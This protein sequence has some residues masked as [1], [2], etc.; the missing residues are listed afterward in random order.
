MQHDEEEH[1]VLHEIGH[2]LDYEF[3]DELRGAFIQAVVRLLIGAALFYFV[4]FGGGMVLT[5]VGATLFGLV[6]IGSYPTI[7]GYFHYL[8]YRW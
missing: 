5:V 8:S 1:E 6:V 2:H 3:R 7:F 4:F